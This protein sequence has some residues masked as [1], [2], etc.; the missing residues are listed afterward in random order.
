MYEEELNKEDEEMKR[1][2]KLSFWSLAISSATCPTNAYSSCHVSS[3]K[4]HISFFVKLTVNFNVGDQSDEPI[5]ESGTILYFF[6]SQ[7]LE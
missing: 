5:V 1:K 4:C 7:G 2:K 6:F 3:K